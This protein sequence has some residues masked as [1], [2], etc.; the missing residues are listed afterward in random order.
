MQPIDN[1]RHIPR[2]ELDVEIQS[3][4]RHFEVRGANITITE[5]KIERL[6]PR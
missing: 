6:V 2:V 5:V 4:P 3:H 1:S